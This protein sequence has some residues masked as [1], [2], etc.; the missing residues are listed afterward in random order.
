MDHEDIHQKRSPKLH[1]SPK[2]NDTSWDILTTLRW[3]SSPSRDAAIQLHDP[4]HTIE[5]CNFYLL[6]FHRDRM[7]SAAQAFQ[8]PFPEKLHGDAGL[9][10][11]EDMLLGAA[12]SHADVFP[13][14][15]RIRVLLSEVGQVSITTSALP[16]SV[17]SRLLLYPTPLLLKTYLID[18]PP[19]YRIFLS[20][21]PTSP[22]LHTRH[23]TTFRAHYDDLRSLLPNET[24]D[25]ATNDGLLPEILLYNQDDE[26]MEGTFTTPYLNRDSHLV[27]PQANAG[28][29]LGTT[30]RWALERGW[31]KADH[32]RKDEIHVGMQVWLSNSVRGWGW[33][34]VEAWR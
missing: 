10:A 34:V 23:K 12:L 20:P 8:R 5:Q 26:L 6:P 3:D 33:G 21:Y 9:Q 2:S 29:N 19:T 25:S 27:T 17:P 18:H 24:T 32:I 13:N 22:N 14:S 30:R 28:G 7:L 1:P 31:C 4:A 11:F 15:L 16:K